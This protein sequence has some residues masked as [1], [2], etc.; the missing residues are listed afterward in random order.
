MKIKK[1]LLLEIFF[2][3]IFNMSYNIMN[4]NWKWKKCYFQYNLNIHILNQLSTTIEK[5]LKKRL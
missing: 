1:K 4:W 2:N 5:D 3:D